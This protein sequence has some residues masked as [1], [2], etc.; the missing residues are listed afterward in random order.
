M[1]S[2]LS[3]VVVAF[4]RISKFLLSEEL[5]EPYLVDYGLKHGVEVD[6]GFTWE[7][8]GRL[9]RKKYAP[10]GEDKAKADEHGKHRTLLRIVTPNLAEEAEVKGK[11]EDTPFELRSL[12]LRVP[13]GSLV[14]VIGRVGSGKVCTVSPY[15][16]T[17]VYVMFS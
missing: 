16:S 6:G 15:L 5:P 7:I 1:L 10:G 11:E 8:A 12:R 2:S 13:K 4:D 14:A 17:S 9:E 3:D